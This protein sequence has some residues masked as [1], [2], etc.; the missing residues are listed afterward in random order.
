MG[1]TLLI[2]VFGLVAL[3]FIQFLFLASRYKRVPSDKVLVVYGRTGSGS[4]ETYAGGAAFVWP[5]IQDYEYLD[6]TPMEISFEEKFTSKDK[7]S[8]PIKSKVTFAISNQDE[9]MINA[10]E[11]LLGQDEWRIKDIG[12]DIIRGVMRITFEEIDLVNIAVSQNKVREGVAT[13]VNKKINMIGLELIN[14]DLDFSKD[15]NS[16]LKELERKFKEKKANSFE[17]GNNEDDE[18]Q[19]G[20]LNQKII[21]NAKERESLIEE[22]LNLLVR[23]KNIR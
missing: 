20:I 1:S 21:E 4:V 12:S 16:Y 19:L 14:M 9:I 3:I 17:I 15:S 2:I 10:A 23:F 11:R 7:I 5:V 8:I 22:K 18:K 13:M 6:L